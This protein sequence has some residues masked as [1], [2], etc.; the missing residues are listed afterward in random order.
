MGK[1]LVTGGAGFIGSHLVDRL[2]KDKKEVIVLDNFDKQ[3]HQGKKPV[4]LNKGATYIEGDIRDGRALKKSLNGVDTIFH[5]A[6]KVGVG[7][8]MYEIKEYVD[9]NTMGT[10]FLWD[11]IVNNKVKVK[12]FIVASSM[13]IY[14][15]GAYTCAKCG[16]VTPYLRADEELKRKIWEPVC[17]ACSAELKAIPT[18][19]DKKLLSTSVYAITKKDQEELS[20]NIGVSYKIPTVALRFFNVYGPRQSL[21]N[22]YTGACAI[23]SSRVKNDNSPLIFEDGLQT[24]DFIDV[25]D[26]IDACI[27]AMESPKADYKV[28]NVGSGKATT[29]KEVA[30]T[31]ID[32]YGKN[33]NLEIVNRYRVG[34]IRHCYGDITK[35]KEI[36]FMPKISLR[37]GLK[38]LVEWGKGEEAVDM[39]DK[40]NLELDKRNLKL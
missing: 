2:V 3:V 40:A 29:I 31:L 16:E 37:D 13:S 25:R 18:R 38:N 1:I 5:F 33:M 35:V 10:A 15:E 28:F 19:E 20:I 11:Y 9:A 36:G 26:I 14:G 23:F 17:P 34:D 39:T 21:S 32:L 27:L 30:N 8:S 6:A 4:Y 12:K 7:Q 22:P 24:R